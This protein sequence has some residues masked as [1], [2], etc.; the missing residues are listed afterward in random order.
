MRVTSVAEGVAAVLRLHVERTD[1]VAEALRHFLATYGPI[2]VDIEM[3]VQ[4]EPGRHEHRRP[5]HRVR[6]QDVLGDEVLRDRPVRVEALLSELADGGHVVDQGVEPHVRHESL[7][8][9]H[10]DAPREPALRARDAEVLER[11]AQHREHLVPIPLRPHEVRLRL[12]RGEQA[13][14]ILPH[15]EEVVLLLDE[16]GNGPVVGT[17]AVDELLLGVE[18]LAARAVQAAVAAEVDV[19]G[20]VDLL[21][22]RLHGP[23]VIGVGRAD[24]AVVGEV[25]LLPRAAED[26]ADLVGVRLRT[27]ARGGRGLGDL[28]AVLVS[29]GQEVRVVPALAPEARERVADQHRVRGAE[30]RLG[31]H[32]VEGRRDVDS[33][34]R[35]GRHEVTR[36]AS[37]SG[38]V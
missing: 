15:L 23:H 8:E 27:F 16:V 38:S 33:S 1:D 18:A 25:R 19:A 21:E 31:V 22:D 7:V 28:V 30:V 10:R 35:V 14:L 5:V 9:R 37:A 32:V 20:V 2:S 12:E 11:L 29:P 24:E 13:L 6:L 36:G 4:R 3:V 34:G 26:P 17:L